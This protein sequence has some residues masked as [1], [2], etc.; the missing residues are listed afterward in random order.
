MEKSL[1]TRGLFCIS[2]L[3]QH[4]EMEF[5]MYRTER[6]C[7][8]EFGIKPFC[9]IAYKNPIKKSTDRKEERFEVA[10]NQMK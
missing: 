4:N 10:K 5:D 9:S 1:E 3:L 2:L 6:D 8:S 7:N